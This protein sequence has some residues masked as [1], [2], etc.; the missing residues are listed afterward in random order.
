MK[1]EFQHEKKKSHL[2]SHSIQLIVRTNNSQFMNK[3]KKLTNVIKYLNC[4]LLPLKKK[5]QNYFKENPIQF[6]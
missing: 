2:H 1:I 4:K 3:K 5:T 6:F